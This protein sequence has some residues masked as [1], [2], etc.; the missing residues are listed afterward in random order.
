M[1]DTFNEQ[2]LQYHRASPPGKIEVVPTK[3]LA[4]QRDL[5]LAYSPGVA[6]ACE[7]IVADP[8]EVSTVTARGNLVAVITNGT[9]VLGLG[10]IG[11]LASKPVMEGKGV[12]FKKF[13]GIDVFDIEISESDPDKLVETIASLEPTF[14][15]INL[16]DIK[17]PECFYIERQLRDRM[18]IPVFHDD[19]HGTAIITAAAV[20]NGLHLIGKDI[21]TVKLVASGAG[22]AG[23]ACLD[24]LVSLGLQRQN[25]IVCDS[26][27]VLFQG[28]EDFDPSK[29]AYAADTTARNLAEAI[30]DADIFLGLSKAGVLSREMVKAMAARPLILALANPTPEIMPEE[31]KAARP[32]AIIATGRSDYPNQVNN[33]LCFPYIF[34]G[35]LDVGAT[36]INREMQLAC[37]RALAQLAREP[38]SSEEMAAAGGE[39]VP[40]GPEYLI[41]KPF[42]S[43]LLLTLPPAVAKAAME[44]GVATHPITDFDAYRQRLSQYVY[45]SGMVMRPVFDRAKTD[46]KRIIYAQGEEE[47]VLWAAQAVIDDGIAYPVLI[48]RRQRVEQLIDELGLHICPDQDFDLIDQQNNPYYEDCWREYHR[49]CGRHG[50]DPNNA[51]IRVNTRATVV[52]ALLLRLGH[53][54]ALIC[55]LVGNYPDHVDYVLD[56]IGL[57]EGV[58]TP[59]A[60]DMLITPQGP[61]FICDT[62]LNENPSAEELA[63]ITL[64]AA[65]EVRRFVTPKVALLSR[66]N[67]GSYKSPQAHKMAEALSIIRQRAPDLEVEGEMRGDVALSEG[68][69]TSIFPKSRLIGAANLL[70]MPNVDA[71]NISYTLL[72]MLTNGVAIGPIMLGLAQPAHVLTPSSAARRIINMSAIAAV[73]A[74]EAMRQLSR[75]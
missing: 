70:I 54:D 2:A 7:A 61:L 57:R 65:E 33:V 3:P 29:A 32:D 21:G 4:N 16:E 31:A 63:D 50:V 15:G 1:T 38:H 67:F 28:R 62:H 42:E 58:R 18:K 64:L 8:R 35:A 44:S 40:F 71:A 22:A 74:Q 37:V 6:A 47:R 52:G 73:D 56:I 75:S 45:R 53:G 51:Q 25:V 14:G 26:R 43:R 13:A 60:L 46:R 20:I 12:L 68:L 41:P 72:K 10:N 66:S 69:R 49:L 19:Q 11:P 36:T 34:R 30:V 27:G 9:A 55:G 5:A 48:G 17:A 24:L 39:S 23:I 59:A